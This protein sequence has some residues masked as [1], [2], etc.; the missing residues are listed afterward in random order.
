VLTFRQLPKLLKNNL[1]KIV[2]IITNV[3]GKQIFSFKVILFSRAKRFT[4]S[5]HKTRAV[6]SP[7]HPGDALHFVMHYSA[8]IPLLLFP[9]F[10]TLDYDDALKIGCKMSHLNIA[11]DRYASIGTVM[12]YIL[13][14]CTRG[15][16][17]KFS[18]RA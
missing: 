18:G 5:D 9:A 3:C 8:I 1:Q 4:L 10:R 12:H 6:A 13:V 14:I 17:K 7:T 2:L 11:F 16:A 15:K